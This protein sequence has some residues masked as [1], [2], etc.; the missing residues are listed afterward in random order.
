MAPG[1]EPYLRIRSASAAGALPTGE[2]GY[3]SDATGHM[4]L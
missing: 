1:I 4:Q 3:L 2:L